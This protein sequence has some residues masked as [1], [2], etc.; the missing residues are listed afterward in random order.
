[1]T[2]QAAAVDTAPRNDAQPSLK[3]RLAGITSGLDTAR[4]L[5]ETASIISAEKLDGR[6]HTVST[7]G[8]KQLR[9]EIDKLR[10]LHTD[11]ENVMSQVARMS[12]DAARAPVMVVTDPDG[13]SADLMT[14]INMELAQIEGMMSGARS[15]GWGEGDAGHIL[16]ASHE[17]IE[18]LESLV[19][20]YASYSVVLDVEDA[21]AASAQTVKAAADFEY[22]E[23]ELLSI[24]EGYRSLADLVG[25]AHMLTDAGPAD[26]VLEAA[27]ERA[28][29]LDKRVL[30]FKVPKSVNKP[31]ATVKPAAVTAAKFPYDVPTIPEGRNVMLREIINDIDTIIGLAA[32]VSEFTDA[33]IDDPLYAIVNSIKLTAKQASEK[34]DKV[35]GDTKIIRKGD[36]VATKEAEK[37]SAPTHPATGNAAIGT[38]YRVIALLEAGRMAADNDEERDAD[39]LYAI[40]TTTEAACTS[41]KKLVD[42]L[43]AQPVAERPKV[44]PFAV[45]AE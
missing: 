21:P 33:S 8:T 24:L 35:F 5:I 9:A 37:P 44:V 28:R 6:A 7:V 36:V 10:A 22:D 11:F 27:L 14:H 39:R 3:V 38:L 40:G 4:E 13:C 34:Y 31:S 20:R 41:L 43:R 30:S 15:L 18:R 29:R 23:E 17:A 25:A 19:G 1:M 32:A 2:S 16:Y 12:I 42:E 26:S 45:A